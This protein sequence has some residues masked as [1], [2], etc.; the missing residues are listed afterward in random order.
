MSKINA[1]Y[2]DSR[3]EKLTEENAE[4]KKEIHNLKEWYKDLKSEFD[5]L[6]FL[7]SENIERREVVETSLATL[8][9]KHSTL[10]KNVS[11]LETQCS[12]VYNTQTKTCSAVETQAQYS[13]LSTLLL[14]G[15]AIPPYRVRED[16]KSGVLHVLKEYLGI[17]IHPLAVS[18]CHRLRNKRTVLLRFVNQDERE[19]VYRKRTKPVKRG[20]AVHESLTSERLDVVK[21]LKDLY[22][23]R[24][25]R[26]SRAT[27]LTRE[28]ST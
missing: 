13:R 28:G 3:F 24:G 8:D 23:P 4:L 25:T 17:V 10:V 1:K 19:A 22:Y 27:I 2:V 9:S 16:T 18:A 7:I 26:S 12:A 11:T 5:S 15:D 21:I 20:L 6:Q 14:S